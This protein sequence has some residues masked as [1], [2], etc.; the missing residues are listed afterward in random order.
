MKARTAVPGTGG[1]AAV[2]DARQ[3]VS[4]LYQEHAL[5]LVKLAVLMTGEQE[6][7]EDVVQDA[8]LAL[9]R[10][11]P[12]L[13]DTGSAVGY[14][15]ST[16]LNGCRMIHRVKHRRRGGAWSP[17][18]ARCYCPT[19]RPSAS[20]AAGPR[21]AGSAGARRSR[22]RRSSSP[23][24]SAWSCSGRPAARSPARPRPRRTRPRRRRYPGTT[25]NW[26]TAAAPARR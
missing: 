14:L 3:Q 9:Y 19:S 1:T 24:P 22:P 8:F 10:R 13:R 15:R 25:W 5:P 4:A 11:W 6:T 18:S 12:S 7:A 17:G 16:V 2:P 21:A 20:G 26:R 23:S